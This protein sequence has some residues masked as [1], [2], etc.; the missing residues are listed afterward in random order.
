[1]FLWYRRTT[2]NS[3][4]LTVI[5]A[6]TNLGRAVFT[7]NR[8]VNCKK[9]CVCCY[10]PKARLSDIT[11]VFKPRTSKQSQALYEEAVALPTKKEMEK[12]MKKK[13]M[14]LV[15][16]SPTTQAIVS[17]NYFQSAFW[18]IE[19]FDV[20]KAVSWDRLH[21]FNNGLFSDHIWDLLKLV[22]QE[23]GRKAETEVDQRLLHFT[24]YSHTAMML[25]VLY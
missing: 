20:H 11:S 7:L 4:F 12:A 5:L 19:G 23:M 16:V 15:K 21:G 8:G 17:A 18:D 25:R 6:A 10:V 1:M 13:G 14:R 2:K 9:P 22:L 3:E 24:I